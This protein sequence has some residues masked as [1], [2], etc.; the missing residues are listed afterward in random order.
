LQ[1]ERVKENIDVNNYA[2]MPKKFFHN[3]EERYLSFDGTI[4]AERSSKL[5]FNAFA[6]SRFIMVCVTVIAGFTVVFYILP[7]WTT[8]QIS[9]RNASV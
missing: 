9:Q 1:A 5:T 8:L 2:R 3:K 4:H 6:S 7:K